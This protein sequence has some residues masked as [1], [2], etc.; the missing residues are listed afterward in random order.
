EGFLLTVMPAFQKLAYVYREPVQPGSMLRRKPVKEIDFIEDM[1]RIAIKEGQLVLDA[2][3]N[4]RA[5]P[6][7]GR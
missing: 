3:P 1:A 5:M 6:S 4:T 2:A 7:P